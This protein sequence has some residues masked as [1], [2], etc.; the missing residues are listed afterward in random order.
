MIRNIEAGNHETIDLCVP[1]KLTLLFQIEAAQDPRPTQHD[2][3]EV[4]WLTR[5]A[6]VGAG[7]ERTIFTGN[8]GSPFSAFA[9][10]SLTNRGGSGYSYQSVTTP[11]GNFTFSST[12]TRGAFGAGNPEHNPQAD[13]MS[14]FQTMMQGMIGGGTA[15]ITQTPG[16]QRLQ[17]DGTRSPPEAGGMLADFNPMRDMIGYLL[18]GHPQL[19][20]PDGVAT[21]GEFDA[22]L[23]NLMDQAHDANR[24]PPAPPAEVAAMPKKP[25]TAEMVGE[26]GAADC[27]IC[28]GEALLGEEVTE[29][30]CSHWYH[31]TC[32]EPWLSTNNSCPQCRKTVEEGRLEWEQKDKE[33]RRK[34]RAARREKAA[35]TNESGANSE[36]TRG[37]GAESSGTRNRIRRMFGGGHD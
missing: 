18:T 11:G 15:R 19:R 4:E 36:S 29:M 10:P 14:H 23:S 1:H 21:D 32:I 9:P 8:P 20:N 5:G 12:T 37:E 25:L 16:S 6:G 24:P 17:F 2:Q 35:A 13:I 27:T 26:T 30:W 28:L 3:A 33:E 22:I 7:A 31:T 34:L